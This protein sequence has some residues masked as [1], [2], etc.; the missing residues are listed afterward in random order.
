MDLPMVPEAVIFAQDH[1]SDAQLERLVQQWKE[2]HTKPI[3][4]SWGLPWS[5]GQ[6]ALP[7][8]TP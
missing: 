1:L 4:E 5:N 8:G 6:K 2:R 3:D 7:E